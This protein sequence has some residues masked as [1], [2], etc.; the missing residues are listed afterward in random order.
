M[1]QYFTQFCVGWTELMLP[2]K[3]E[4]TPHLCDSSHHSSA[5]F[6]SC[7]N[8]LLIGKGQNPKK[9]TVHVETSVICTRKI[10]LVRKQST[11]GYWSNSTATMGRLGMLWSGFYRRYNYW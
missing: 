5:S 3:Q 8:L 4:K 1:T 9:T 11:Y 6:F 10:M 2:L 7:E